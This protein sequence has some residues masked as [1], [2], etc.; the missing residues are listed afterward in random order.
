MQTIFLKIQKNELQSDIYNVIVSYTQDRIIP[1]STHYVARNYYWKL[2]G[3]KE[4]YDEALKEFIYSLQ[5]MTDEELFYFSINDI[6]DIIVY[7]E[8]YEEIITIKS[9]DVEMLIN[10]KEKEKVVSTFDQYIDYDEIKH[11]AETMSEEDYAKKYDAS[12]EPN[13]Y[14][15]Y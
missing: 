15:T 3:P 7:R 6:F 8:E 9:Y 5:Q 10:S 11:D 13:L 14:W 4:S 1:I 2:H 12:D